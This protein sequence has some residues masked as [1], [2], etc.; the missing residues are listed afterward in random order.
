MSRCL[1]D[2]WIQ[3]ISGETSQH[4]LSWL[5]PWGVFLYQSPLMGLPWLF[6]S[7][8]I[9]EK[10][11]IPHKTERNYKFAGPGWEVLSAMKDWQSQ[12]SVFSLD[13]LSSILWNQHVEPRNWLPFR[14]SRCLHRRLTH[15][16]LFFLMTFSIKM[17]WRLQWRMKTSTRGASSVR[18]L[19]NNVS[20]CGCFGEILHSRSF[21][22]LYIDFSVHSLR[23]LSLSVEMYT[24]GGFLKWWFPNWTIS[25]LKSMVLGIPISRTPYVHVQ[26][27]CMY[28]SV[29]IYLLR[30]ETFIQFPPCREP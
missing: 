26:E 23:C 2:F 16:C 6:N 30:M 9:G 3:I 8:F 28:L 4:W 10:M 1:L 13:T 18:S 22:S 25:L 12:V 11:M 27:M 5:T 17:E 19:K 14:R 21:T 7:V 20:T 29:C 24:Y 15:L